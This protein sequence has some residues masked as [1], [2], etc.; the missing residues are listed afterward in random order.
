[1]LTSA[2]QLLRHLQSVPPE[3]ENQQAITGLVTATDLAVAAAHLIGRRYSRGGHR[4][5]SAW[6]AR[7]VWNFGKTVVDDL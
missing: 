3:Q 2:D 4:R 1:M 5:F 7:E 6:W